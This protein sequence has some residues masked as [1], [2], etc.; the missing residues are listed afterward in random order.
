MSLYVCILKR[1]AYYGPNDDE[2]NELEPGINY[3]DIQGVKVI[4][5]QESNASLSKLQRPEWNGHDVSE[6]NK[7]ITY[8][9]WYIPSKKWKL[10]INGKLQNDETIKKETD[11]DLDKREE[12]LS[13]TIP[14]LFISKMYKNYIINHENPIK[15]ILPKY[16]NSVT[17]KSDKN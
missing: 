13:K 6:K 7:K 4:K 1:S 17:I 11:P 12:Q 16:L 15:R 5:K 8:G 2:S 9:A 3:L 10:K 14:E